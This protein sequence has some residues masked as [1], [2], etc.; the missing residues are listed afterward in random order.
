MVMLSARKGSAWLACSLTVS[1]CTGAIGDVE[2]GMLSL[3]LQPAATVKL[4]LLKYTVSHERG[5][6]RSG[7][8]A[9]G[10]QQ[11][12][13]FNVDDL[14]PAFGY[15][16]TAYAE[17]TIIQAS[18][19]TVCTGQASFEVRPAQSTALSMRLQCDG[20]A[21]TGTANAGVANNCPIVG[22]LSASPAQAPVGHDVQ[23]KAEVAS[24]LD[25]PLPL[26][27]EWS[28]DSGIL[29]NPHATQTRFLCDRPGV[30][31]VRLTLS[32]G[33]QACEE[34]PATVNV[35]CTDADCINATHCASGSARPGATNNRAPATVSMGAL[36]A[37]GSSSALAGTSSAA[38]GRAAPRA[39][40]P[41]TAPRDA[42]AQVVLD[43]GD[44]WAGWPDLPDLPDPNEPMPDD[45]SERERR[46]RDHAEAGSDGRMPSQAGA[47]ASAPD[48]SQAGEPAPEP[49]AGS[50]APEP[51]PDAGAGDQDWDDMDAGYAQHSDAMNAAPVTRAGAYSESVRSR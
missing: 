1:A 9:I 47:G 15:V 5:F 37:A 29:G 27:Y 25:G 33:D 46:R 28:A 8:V 4:R 32:D 23:L 34:A 24:D 13:T 19:P 43:A 39:G 10:E 35:T 42:G 50:G 26:M 12:F 38:A 17:G 48:P 49:E 45:E 2:P 36:A 3:Q 22:V 18:T 11:T 40:A 6:V 31:P 7:P 44:P 20:V 16:V 41:A 14:P 51:L 21:R 30:F